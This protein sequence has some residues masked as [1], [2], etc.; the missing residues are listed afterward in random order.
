MS[1]S[2]FL[3]RNPNMSNSS[4][5]HFVTPFADTIEIPA[6]SAVGAY[7]VSLTKKP[8]SVYK[9]TEVIAVSSQYSDICYTPL[10]DPATSGSADVGTA[11]YPQID[12]TI[13]KGEYTKREFL[14]HFQKE[15]NAEIAASASASL[16]VFPYS[17]E[18]RNT[19]D[20][21]FLGLTPDLPTIAPWVVEN[22]ATRND[23]STPTAEATPTKIIRPSDEDGSNIVAYWSCPSAV[24]PL[25]RSSD[26]AAKSST[27]NK[28]NFRLINNY[29]GGVPTAG[30]FN[31]YGVMFCTQAQFVALGA[32]STSLTTTQVIN[33]RQAFP[34]APIGIVCDSNPHADQGDF[35]IYHTPTNQ[36]VLD[37]DPV[38][39]AHVETDGMVEGNGLQVEFYQ[40]DF[41]CGDRSIQTDASGNPLTLDARYYFKVLALGHLTG[42]SGEGVYSSG[43][44][45]YDSRDEGLTI[46]E[47]LIQKCFTY[48]ADGNP[49]GLVPRL[50]WANLDVADADVTDYGFVVD[51]NFIHQ[52]PGD[53]THGVAGVVTYVSDV[54]TDPRDAEN[55]LPQILGSA[56]AKLSPNGY[57]P[58]ENNLFGYTDLFG[59]TENYNIEISIPVKAQTNSTTSA[60]LG[61]ERPVVF[62]LNSVFSGA[63]REVESSSIHRSVYPPVLK[64]LALRN[65]RPIRTNQIE[66]RVKRA[67]SNKQATEITDCQVELLIN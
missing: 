62:G 3:N 8:I 16:P 47:E 51:G 9:D 11:D 12:F 44:T 32:G 25:Q 48:D 39:L 56:S 45:I 27:Q 38:V 54:Q 7:Q 15:A 58:D 52:T 31:R 64:Q 4:G 10:D 17:Y 50:W 59:N 21:I 29:K 5:D 55:T 28:F 53:T 41:G 57:N 33:G 42:R 22:V 23:K 67:S 13:T 1:H 35:Y 66:V 43:D 30:V 24:Y 20:E 14:E 2:V 37:G 63:L 60:D 40:G 26:D 19:D 34:K 36:G 65:Q 49:D 61:V 46:D 6:G 18:V